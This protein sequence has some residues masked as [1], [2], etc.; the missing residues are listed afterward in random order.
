L[1]DE[2]DE[3]YLTT[4][5]EAGHAVAAVVF[6]GELIS[7]T[8]DPPSEHPE[9]AG[10]TEVRMDKPWDLHIVVYAGPWAEARFQWPRDSV[11]SLDEQDDDGRLFRDY[12]REAFDVIDRDG[13]L[14]KYQQLE[15]GIRPD[16]DE[17]F[18]PPAIGIA[19]LEGRPLDEVIDE[20]NQKWSRQL[21]EHCWS[22]I[23]I[24]AGM[25]LDG[26]T[27]VDV[28]TAAVRRLRRHG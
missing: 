24:V 12:V 15:K 9:R 3:R 16:N 23:R 8:I 13:D 7:V 6:G 26:C 5:H 21:E 27:D 11:D 4:H 22:I 2:P 17:R 28:I 20:R 25:L 1:T 19:E 10:N 14:E 18:T